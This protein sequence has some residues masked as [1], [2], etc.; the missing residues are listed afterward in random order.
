CISS[1]L[2]NT[3]KQVTLIPNPTTGL[4]T[5]RNNGKQ[6]ITTVK[7]INALGVSSTLPYDQSSQIDISFLPNG[8]YFLNIEFM[9]GIHSTH[10]VILVK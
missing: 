8:V 5:I 1:T 7:I 4:L 10:K 9:D 2:D 3:I 6:S